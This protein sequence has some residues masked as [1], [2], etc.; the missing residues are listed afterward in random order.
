MSDWDPDLYHRFRSYRDEAFEAILTRLAP[1]DAGERPAGR[2]VDLGCGTGENT[3][4]LARRF[5]GAATV[6]IDSSAAM[7]DRALKLREGLEPALRDR[8]S[9]VL[10][11]IRE[12]NARHEHPGEHSMIFSNAALQWLTEHREIFIRCFEALA[13]G[14]RLVVQMPANDHETAQ[15][16]LDAMAHEEPWRARLDGV[17]SPSSTVAAPEAYHRMLG[18]IGFAGVDCHYHTFHHPMASPAE[19]VEWCR[20]TV[21]RRY[22]DPLDPEA[23]AP[24]VAALTARLESAYATRG[25]LTFNFR[26]LFIWAHRPAD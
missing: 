6:G 20:A 14:G 26:R 13:P 1:G 16:T 11:D 9:F 12:F 5:A 23:R 4:E 24:F 25:P 21:L 2:I 10:G 15:V 7:I 18:E 3:A 22:L 19:I 8:L 17:R